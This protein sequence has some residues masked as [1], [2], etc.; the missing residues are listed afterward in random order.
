MASTTQK[1]LLKAAEMAI[2]YVNKFPDTLDDE[3]KQEVKSVL[4]SIKKLKKELLKIPTVKVGDLSSKS[5]HKLFGLTLDD[6]EPFDWQKAA[7]EGFSMYTEK[8][9]QEMQH[10]GLDWTLKA[11]EKTYKRAPWNEPVAR[12]RLDA[13]LL[14]TTFILGAYGKPGTVGVNLQFETSLTWTTNKKRVQGLADYTLFYDDPSKNASNLLVIEAKRRD[15]FNRG[16]AELLA[17]MAMVVNARLIAGDGENAGVF[18]LLSDGYTFHF[19]QLSCKMRYT[20]HILLW[21]MGVTY[22]CGIKGLLSYIILE[23]VNMAAESRKKVRHPSDLSMSPV[24]S[25]EVD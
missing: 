12:T 8:G 25:M 2:T 3:G 9:S 7:F 10:A 16:P 6:T 11:Y 5:V 18:G 24:G 17:Y 1:A 4:T 22:Q 13:L 19:Y 23:A 21:D 20:V 14:T 15:E